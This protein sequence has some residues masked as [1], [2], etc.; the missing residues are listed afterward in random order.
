MATTELYEIWSGPFNGFGDTESDYSEESDMNEE[1]LFEDDAIPT[2]S[3]EEHRRLN[4]DSFRQSRVSSVPLVL[5]QS[6]YVEGVMRFEI[7]SPTASQLNSN[8]LHPA[9]HRYIRGIDSLDTLA[10]SLGLDT[11][12]NVMQ[13]RINTA[14][15]DPTI[16]TVLGNLT[17][18]HEDTKEFLIESHYVAVVN[19]IISALSSCCIVAR[20]RYKYSVGGLCVDGRYSVKGVTDT[21]YFNEEN[22]IALISEVKTRKS[23]RDGYQWYRSSRGFQTLGP[24][25]A[26]GAPTLLLNQH[27]A[28]LLFKDQTT[29]DVCIF[30][31]QGQRMDI[32]SLQFV[33]AIIY[34]LLRSSVAVKV[35]ALRRLVLGTFVQPQGQPT[36]VDSKKTSKEDQTQKRGSSRIGNCLKV[37]Q[38]PR[39]PHY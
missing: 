23:W 16:E 7:V 36:T 24:L 3:M 12:S 20:N 5:G 18:L 33:T 13:D 1:E 29:G 4:L 8:W 14:L 38:S 27:Q 31:S 25:Y 19:S 10:T 28:V 2:Y 34:C 15:T 37:L 9:L 30:P 32:Y 21:V 26:T 22:D 17:D 11:S 39:C 35:R 6:G